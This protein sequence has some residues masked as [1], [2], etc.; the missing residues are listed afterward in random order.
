MTCCPRPRAP[1]ATAC[2][3]PRMRSRSSAS[4]GT[5]GSAS[6]TSELIVSQARIPPTAESPAHATI[7][8]RKPSVI[9]AGS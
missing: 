2:P 1:A 8:I 7:A 4:A 6:R 3:R 9:A 5:S